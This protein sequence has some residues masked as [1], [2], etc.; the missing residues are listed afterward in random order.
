M[1]TPKP[2]TDE[3]ICATLTLHTEFLLSLLGSWLSTQPDWP[4]MIEATHAQMRDQFLF[5]MRVPSIDAPP[6]NHLAIQAESVRQLDELMA[7]LYSALSTSSAAP[8][9]K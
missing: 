9:P 2:T 5:H 3:Y 6:M 8:S 7:R 4:Q 1:E